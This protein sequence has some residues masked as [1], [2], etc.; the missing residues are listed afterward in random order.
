MNLNELL[1]QAQQRRDLRDST[2]ASYRKL[3]TRIDV[4]DDSLGKEELEARL[5]DV[6]NVNTRRATVVAI[7]SVLQVNMKVP[8]GI[9]RRY[10]LPTED[11]LRFALM[12]CRYETRGL[13]MM[14]AGLRIG[15]A[16]AVTSNQLNG[17]RL[18]ID[19]QVLEFTDRGK[20]VVRIAPVKAGYGQVLVPEWLIPQIHA[21][22]ETDIPGHVRS[23]FWHWG[24]RHGIKLN[25]HSLRHWHATWLLNS[26]VN[27]VA[28][29]KQLRHSDP[30]ITMRAYIQTSEDD[31]RR[32]FNQ[33]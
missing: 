13:L 28:V 1:E 23:A 22:G 26:G 15:E 27:I 16:C 30:S 33:K 19:R 24:R 9:P 14:Y 7:R 3:L 17:D 11:Q 32:A 4:T 25:P 29:S 10:D 12:Q 21:L 18:L 2:V 31:V 5:L 6:P 8:Q 20:H